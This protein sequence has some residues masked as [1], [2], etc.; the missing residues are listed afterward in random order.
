M[1]LSRRRFVAATA[2]SWLCA[3]LPR[4]F[5]QSTPGKQRGPRY[6]VTFFLRGG[7]DPVYTVDPKTR[8]EVADKVDVP[9]GAND[10][11]DGGAMGFG[12]H[13]QKLQKWAPKMA[14]LRGVQVK[15]ANH[16]TGAFQTLR[17]RTGVTTGMPSLYDVIGQSRDSQPLASVTL[18][19]LTSFEHSPGALAAPTGVGGNGTTSLDA[20]D[21]LSDEEVDLLARVYQGHLARFPKWQQS[22]E[23][24]RTREHVAQAGAFFQR[25]KTT[26]RFKAADWDAKKGSRAVRVA[27]DLQRTLWFLEND[28]TRGVAV[29]VVFDWDSHY[30]N[31]DKQAQSTGDFTPVLARFLEEL[32]TRKNAHGVLADQTALVIGS[33]LGRFPIINGNLGKDHFP[34]APY[35]FFGPSFNVG[36]AFVPTGK[37]MEGLPVSAETGKA[38]DTGAQHVV[39]DD[40]GTTLMHIAGLNPTT[41]GYRGRRLRFLER[42]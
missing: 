4:S 12:P 17:M 16:E 20:V 36:Q 31:A 1:L 23:A 34:E 5:A 19:D 33:E 21:A 41:Y 30:R 15:T 9:Y 8:G 2:S 38:G 3:G 42:A 25:M 39:L 26:A 32:H 27:E 7:I 6:F 40:V 22:P 37:M 28:L 14:V 29:R 35:M 11:V 18:G 24:T 13:F 10:I